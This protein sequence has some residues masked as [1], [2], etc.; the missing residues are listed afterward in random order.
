M[1]CR[2]NSKWVVVCCFFLFLT[3]ES[4]AAAKVSLFTTADSQ[5]QAEIG[6]DIERFIAAPADVRL[7][8]IKALGPADTLL[9]LQ[10]E[11]G[12]SLAILP[13]DALVAYA[14]LAELG[15]ADANQLLSPVRV[16]APLFANEIYFIVRQDSE[17]FSF[18]DIQNAHINVGLPS[19]TTALSVGNLYRLL[20]DQAIPEGNL[21]TLKHDEA[22]ISLITEKGVDVVAIVGD[23]PL[24]LLADMKPEARQYIRLLKFDVSHPSSKGVLNFYSPAT[25]WS[26]NYQNLLA[27]DHA[28]IAVTQYLVAYRRR[29]GDPDPSM[30][31]FIR[32]WCSNSAR[33]K[34]EGNLKWRRNAASGDQQIPLKLPRVD[35]GVCA[36]DSS[37]N[38]Q[39]VCAQELR[40]LGLCR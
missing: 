1:T 25:I 22:L 4:I 38:R 32:S 2:T 19:G 3:A 33:M 29:V 40:V 10:K 6:Q 31:N 35:F 30:R 5:T 36:K 24:K 8:F 26:A 17:Y 18:N 21:S 23:Q 28:S 27:E 34:A 39:P 9:N 16:I 7:G 15:N 37:L 14:N 20:F 12:W 13:L 11:P